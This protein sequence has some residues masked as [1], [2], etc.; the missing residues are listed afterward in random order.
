M[1]CVGCDVIALSKKQKRTINMLVVL[2]FSTPI[3]FAIAMSVATFLDRRER[4]VAFWTLRHSLRNYKIL[5]KLVV[6]LS[7]LNFYS[8]KFLPLLLSSVHYV[9]HCSELST[10]LRKQAKIIKTSN[11][12]DEIQV[13]QILIRCCKL[14]NESAKVTIFLML[15]MDFTELYIAI[16]LLLGRGFSMTTTPKIV[17]SSFTFTCI[18]VSLIIVVSFA[19]KIPNTMEQTSAS[20][21][22][23]YCSDLLK[24]K[25]E[26]LPQNFGHLMLLKALSE[27]KSVHLTVWDMLKVDKS[28]ILSF[29][30][31]ILTFGIL[32]MQIKSDDSD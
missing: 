22:E 9:F 1:K 32:I 30:G 20:F 13:Y 27:L 18:Y 11:A 8:I 12:T 10:A 23:L 6:F 7:M 29:T 28:L 26:V 31:C 24:N 4:Y 14:F 25:K 17:E 2:A 19:A 3:I 15:T 21:Q 16:R 5:E